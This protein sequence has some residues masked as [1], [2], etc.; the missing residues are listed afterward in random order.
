M[1]QKYW[2]PEYENKATTILTTSSNGTP[3]TIGNLRT[4]KP[5]VW[6]D[7]EVINYHLSLLQKC[8]GKN[9]YLNSFFYSKLM[10]LNKYNYRNVR[11]WT[12]KKNLFKYNKII[13]PI[14]VSMVHW[15]LGVINISE[16]CIHYWD[17]M[18]GENSDFFKYMKQ[19]LKDEIADKEINIAMDIDEWPEKYLSNDDPLQLNSSDCGVFLLSFARWVDGDS[20]PFTRTD[21]V[22]LRKQICVEIL[23][24]GIL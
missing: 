2:G 9:L 21:M 19:Y 1:A 22:Y 13:I 17:S 12:K 18:R 20:F 6:L 23:K 8:N 10:K 24:N 3:I 15:V 16:K 7:D 4:L 11:R 5:G 14:N